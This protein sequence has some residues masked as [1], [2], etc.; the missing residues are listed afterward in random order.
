MTLAGRHAC[1]SKTTFK[2]TNIQEDIQQ[3]GF[4]NI[5]VY[6][7]RYFFKKNQLFFR[8]EKYF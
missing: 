3:Y 6:Q 2:G 8:I 1:T 7:Y 4:M 5:K